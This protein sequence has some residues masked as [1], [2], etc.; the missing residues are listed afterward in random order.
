M[1]VNGKRAIGIGVASGAK[2]NVVAVGKAVDER[3]AEIEQLLPIGIELASLYPEDKIADEANNGFILNLIESL[4]IVILIIF[5][6]M[7]SRAGMLIGSSL[8]FSVGGTLLIMLMWGVGLN[9]TSLAAF[10]IAMGMLVDNAI[11]VT[12]NAQIGIKRGKSR[13]QSLIEGAIKPQWA[14]LGATFIAICS[15]LPLYLAPASVAEIVK[16][17]FVVLAVSLGLSWILALCQTTTL[18]ILF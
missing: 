9:R 12:D 8:L 3:L 7:G 16:P 4:V 18:V 11:V 2:D 1:R 15:F 10:I 14:L 5:V 13:Y 17:L 6:V